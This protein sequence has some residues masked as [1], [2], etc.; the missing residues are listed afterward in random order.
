MI[1]YL[2][3]NLAC[4]LDLYGKTEGKVLA[5]LEVGKSDAWIMDHLQI[6]Q[7]KLDEIRNK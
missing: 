5:Y 4:V 1:I 6:T 7:E 2:F 3:V